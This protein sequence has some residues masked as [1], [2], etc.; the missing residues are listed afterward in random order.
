MMDRSFLRRYAASGAV[1]AGLYLLN[2]FLLVPLTS[3]RL[4]AW[5]G[6]DFLAGGLMLCLLNGLLCLTRRRPVERAL[7]A[8]LFLLACGLFWEVV[9]PL[10]LLRSVGDLRDVL[11]VWLG[12]VALLSLWRVWDRL[13]PC[14]APP[15]PPPWPGPGLAQRHR[16][17]LTWCPWPARPCSSRNTLRRSTGW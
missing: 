8:S 14:S 12:G 6:A 1:I 9:T 10:Y 11:A 7:P 13:G 2:R 4:L 17:S 3:C 16:L 5:H 15:G